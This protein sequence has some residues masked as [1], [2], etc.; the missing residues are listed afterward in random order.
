MGHHTGSA[1]LR[2]GLGFGDAKAVQWLRRHDAEKP[3]VQARRVRWRGIAWLR[4][5]GAVVVERGRRWKH[6]HGRG[7][8]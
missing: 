1:R 4:E 8:G 7:S 3:S 2:L 6:R 5:V